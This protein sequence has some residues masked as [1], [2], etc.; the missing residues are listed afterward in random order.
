ML[1]RLRGRMSSLQPALTFANVT[2]CVA[3]FLALGG[4]GYAAVTLPRNSV[5]AK[6]IKA[7]AV[8][9]SKVKDGALVAGDFKAGQLPAG[10][11]G[12]AGPKGDTGA[13]GAN[14]ERGAQGL[15][16]TDGTDGTD[17]QPG[18]NGASTVTVRSTTGTFPYTC[19]PPASGAGTVYTCTAPQQTVTANCNSGERATGGGYATPTG[20]VQAPNES[21]PSPAVGTPTG[22]RVTSP[23]G[24]TSSLTPTAPD[25]TL[26]VNVVCTAP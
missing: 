24:S 7:G 19:M 10:A 17:G 12:D 13:S 5:G 4:T 11:K 18:A 3:L 6:Q 20:G 15:A 23:G 1:N 22:W 14:G 25:G 9:S 26:T 16:G 2:S 8:D 21:T